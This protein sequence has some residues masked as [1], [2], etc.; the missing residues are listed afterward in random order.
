MPGVGVVP[1]TTISI[2]AADIDAP[3]VLCG[4]L[5]E[6]RDIPGKRADQSGSHYGCK[7]VPSGSCLAAGGTADIAGT[8]QTSVGV[9][10]D[11]NN[12]PLCY[13]SEFS[14]F[15]EQ[16]FFACRTASSNKFVTTRLAGSPV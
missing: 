4:L 15:A 1:V 12:V 2:V 5:P 13:I 3:C 16:I 11:H 9:K 7:S 10:M 8:G 14:E 6:C